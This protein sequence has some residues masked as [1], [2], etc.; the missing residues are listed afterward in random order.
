MATYDS[1]K[2]GVKGIVGFT[3]AGSAPAQWSEYT[4]IRGRTI[5]GLPSSGTNDATVGTA[6]TDE[7]DKSKT[8]STTSVSEAQLPE[9]GHNMTLW[10]HVSQTN[11]GPQYNYRS[12]SQQCGSDGWVGDW[13]TGSIGSGSAHGHGAVVTSD[14][15][16]YIQLMAVKKD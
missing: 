14:V 12:Q 1:I 3:T 8:L 6:Y 10:G 15:L 2:K 13:N 7:Q 11:Y 4:P 9:H 16:A 5:V